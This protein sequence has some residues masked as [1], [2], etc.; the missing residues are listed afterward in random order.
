VIC[1]ASASQPQVRH[2]KL[3]SEGNN[4]QPDIVVGFFGIRRPFTPPKSGPILLGGRQSPLENIVNTP[5][6]VII[7]QVYIIS[8]LI[9]S[10]ESDEN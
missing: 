3:F 8:R 7:H 2:Y 4:V 1:G 6:V 10:M 5:L 9:R